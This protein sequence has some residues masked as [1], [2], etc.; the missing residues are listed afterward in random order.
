MG[1]VDGE[2][3]GCAG[4]VRAVLE[5]GHRHV[6]GAATE[7]ESDGFGA[8]KDRME[9]ARC[10]GPPPVVDA[11]GDEVVGAVVGGGN[12]VEHLL[13]GDGGV[14]LGRD[15]GGTCSGREFVFGRWNQ[16]LLRE[17][18]AMLTATRWEKIKINI[19]RIL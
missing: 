6:A 11:S 10:A 19:A 1:E 9:E 18:L 5:Q 2:D 7:I 14:L 17:L 4:G 16:A 8:L 3:G 15:A 13:D 12:G